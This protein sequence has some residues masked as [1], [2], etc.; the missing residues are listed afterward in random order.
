MLAVTCST[1][2]V[3]AEQPLKPLSK[4][5][6]R[7]RYGSCPN[8]RV[9]SGA[10]GMKRSLRESKRRCNYI[11]HELSADGPDFFAQGGAEHHDL[12]LVWR[13]AENLLNVTTH[14]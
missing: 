3:R 8:A 2:P 11:L 1:E 7:L 4:V 14:V 5:T 9:G 6:E 12:L 10:N 13:H